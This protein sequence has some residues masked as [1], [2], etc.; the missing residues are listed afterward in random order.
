VSKTLHDVPRGEGVKME[1]INCARNGC[2]NTFL[3]ATHNQKYCGAEC[4]RIATNSR[5]MQEYYR[6]RDQKA[7]KTRY[8][9]KCKK[10]K[11]SRYNDS[12]VCRPCS[13]ANA[14][15]ANNAV[16]DMLS[17]VSWAS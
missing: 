11:L 15:A 3:K 4:C 12:S 9:Q 2:T 16:Q 5:I 13:T 17:S 8:C 6:K 10:T 14:A 7:G 1:E